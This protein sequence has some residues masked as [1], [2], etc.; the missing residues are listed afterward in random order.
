MT[1]LEAWKAERRSKKADA[2]LTL[3][4]LLEQQRYLNGQSIA[5]IGAAIA[6]IEEDLGSGEL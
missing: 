4:K 5:A 3:R 2:L 1:E 6:A